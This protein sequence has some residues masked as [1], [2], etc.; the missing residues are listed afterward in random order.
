MQQDLMMQGTRRID[1][2]GAPLDA[3]T[4]EQTVSLIEEAVNARG[5][6]VIA[7]G[8]VD[9]VMKARRDPQFAD[10]LR[11]ADLVIADGVPLVW[12]ATLLGNPVR[13]RV[14]GTDL[15]RRCAQVSARTGRAVALIGGR[16]GV[17]ERAA[18]VLEV[19]YSG[20]RL[21]A[22]ATPMPLTDDDSRAMA[23]EIRSRGAAIVL[24]ALGAPRQERWVQTYLD[25]TGAHVGMGVGSAFD[26]LCGDQPRAP[27]WMCDHGL[28]WFYR[29]ILDPRRLVRRYL[30]D[31][32]PF[33]FH[34]LW[35]LTVG[36]FA[37]RSAL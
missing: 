22:I 30:I 20:A 15:V 31:D 26:I 4:F 35:A 17:A 21:D 14:S 25:Q 23:S 12:A 24:V 6:L 11:R 34:L 32:S 19:Q 36:R 3:V 37:R 7:A 10:L 28:E 9:Q 33:I 29:M 18:R 13:G 5:R 8:N 2:L 1:V 27:K 16:P